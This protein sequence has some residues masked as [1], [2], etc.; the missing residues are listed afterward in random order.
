MAAFPPSQDFNL[1]VG[2]SGFREIYFWLV[3]GERSLAKV[4]CQVPSFPPLNCLPALS[5]TFSLHLFFSTHKG[6]SDCCLQQHWHRLTLSLQGDWATGPPG[7]CSSPKLLFWSLHK[8]HR[9]FMQTHSFL[10]LNFGF[11]SRMEG[12]KYPHPFMTYLRFPF[13]SSCSWASQ[14]AW[15]PSEG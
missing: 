1:G 5:Q 14:A 13:P 11:C 10:P 7:S 3:P 8:T 6:C 15:G 4:M 2:C 12:K 9:V